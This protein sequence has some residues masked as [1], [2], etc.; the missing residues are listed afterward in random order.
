M[1]QLISPSNG[2]NEF[3]RNKVSTKNVKFFY[4][5]FLITGEYIIVYLKE[6]EIKN[7]KKEHN[8]RSSSREI[9]GL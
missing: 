5:F 9:T 2:V 1:P 6:K 8:F 4:L 3:T 7:R